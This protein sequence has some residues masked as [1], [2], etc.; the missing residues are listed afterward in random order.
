MQKKIL[1]IGFVLML[2]SILKLQAQ[3]YKQDSTY[4]K[5]FIGNTLFMLAN[6]VSD[7]NSPEMVYRNLSYRV[8]GK[9]VILLK[10]KT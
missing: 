5:Y 10:F 3:Y 2:T 6:V 1:F 8:T 9:D 4:K 7:N